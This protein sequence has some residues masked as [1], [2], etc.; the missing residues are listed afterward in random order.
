MNLTDTDSQ[1]VKITL[2]YR[3]KDINGFQKVI[4]IEDEKAEEML[5]DEKRKEEVNIFNTWWKIL[6]WK[7]SNNITN[8]SKVQGKD[9]VPGE[10]DFYR[11]RDLRIKMCMK[12]WDLK[13]DD[14]VDLPLTPDLVNKLPV[15][16]ILYLSNKYEQV[17]GIDEEEL[18]N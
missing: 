11:F 3:T 4:I 18:G 15:D 13:D 2:H 5:K 6:S 7:D 16:I 10:L 17:I 1:L 9:A 12:K 8:N 14:G